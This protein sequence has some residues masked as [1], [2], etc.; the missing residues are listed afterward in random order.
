MMSIVPLQQGLSEEEVKAA[1]TCAREEVM[2]R[3]R[4]S[5]MN[6]PRDNSS[7]NK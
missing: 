3:N 1:A 4:F 2:I 7:V 6:A 5:E